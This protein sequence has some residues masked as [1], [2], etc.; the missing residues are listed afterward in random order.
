MDTYGVQPGDTFNLYLAYYAGWSAY[1]K[2]AWRSNASLVKYAQA[3][4]KTAL[5]YSNQMQ[6]C[7]D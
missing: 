1:G 3:T 7:G 4:A 5:E 2:G 6:T